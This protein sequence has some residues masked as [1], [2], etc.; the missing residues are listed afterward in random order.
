MKRILRKRPSPA[1]L[2]AIAAVVLSGV[3]SAT[4]AQLISGNQ[5]KNNSV[6]SKDI[7]NR[8]LVRKDFKSG[9]LLRGPRG[10]QGPQGPTGATGPRGADGAPGR[11]GIVKLRYVAGPGTTVTSGFQAFDEAVC[12]ADAPNVIGG[13]VFSESITPGEQ[14]VNSSYPS[15]GTGSGGPGTR[16]WFVAVDPAPGVTGPAVFAFAICSSSPDVGGDFRQKLAK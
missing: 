10:L 7:K 3:G 5:I 2:L 6:T 14:S 15:D 12:P 16:G 1:M 11:D 13:G 9:Q 8:T 4:A